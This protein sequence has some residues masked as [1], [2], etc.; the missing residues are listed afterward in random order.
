MIATLALLLLANYAIAQLK[1]VSPIDLQGEFSDGK[2]PSILKN[3]GFQYRQSF[4]NGMLVEPIAAKKG[5]AQLSWD[6]HFN[7]KITDPF[8]LVVHRGHCTFDEKLKN[9]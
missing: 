5:C 4:S 9:A 3:I 2:I 6:K 7:E 8:Y 1:V